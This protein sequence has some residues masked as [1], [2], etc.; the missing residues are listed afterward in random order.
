MEIR[1][2]NREDITGISRVQV[3]SYLTTYANQFPENIWNTS[4]IM[5]K[6]KIGMIDFL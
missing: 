4:H 3:D 6:S 1:Q 2:A 5:N